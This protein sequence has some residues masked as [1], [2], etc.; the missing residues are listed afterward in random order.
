MIVH[1]LHVVGIPVMPDE[2]D[3]VLI[4]DPDAVLPSSVACQRFEAIARERGEIAELPSSMQLLQFP[5]SH[6]RNPLQTTAEPP[7]EKRLR[8]RVFEGPDHGPSTL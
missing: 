3:A 6:P 1:D 2:A 7:P 8:L 4:V 5:L